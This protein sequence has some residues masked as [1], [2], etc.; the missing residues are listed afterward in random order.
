MVWILG[1]TQS[2]SMPLAAVECRV[3]GG[4]VNKNSIYLFGSFGLAEAVW[5]AK[6]L[7]R[8]LLTQERSL[9]CRSASLFGTDVYQRHV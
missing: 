5:R 6:L 7:P 3:F 4:A 8:K 1:V 2:L 9:R